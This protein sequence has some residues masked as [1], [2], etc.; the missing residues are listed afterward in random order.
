MSTG[1]DEQQ[2]AAAAAAALPRAVLVVGGAGAGKTALCRALIAH[3]VRD[4][5][6]DRVPLLLRVAD[7]AAAVRGGALRV[8]DGASLVLGYLRVTHGAHSRHFA[9]V[10]QALH[11]GRLLLILDGL[12]DAADPPAAA[13][14]GLAGGATRGAAARDRWATLPPVRARRPARPK[15]TPRL[16]PAELFLRLALRPPRRAAAVVALGAR[17]L[18]PPQLAALRRTCTRWGQPSSP[19][20]AALLVG[21]HTRRPP[22]AA[23]RTRRLLRGSRPHDAARRC[24]RR[25]ASRP[26]DVDAPAAAS[27]GVGAAARAAQLRLHV[28]KLV[29]TH[30]FGLGSDDG[31]GRGELTPRLV[32]AA[33]G[34]SAG[35]LQL[36]SQLRREALSGALP[37]LVAH[38]GGALA[39]A[40]ARF[41]DVL[42]ALSLRDLTEAQIRAGAAAPLLAP[43]PPPDT[44]LRRDPAPTPHH[45]AN[46]A[47]PAGAVGAGR[48]LKQG[49]DGGSDALVFAAAHAQRGGGGGGAWL[50][51]CCEAVSGAALR[52]QLESSIDAAKVAI[53]ARHSRTLVGLQLLECA[54]DDAGAES[55]A[56]AL[57]D[58][59]A[60]LPLRCLPSDRTDR[61]A[62]RRRP[63]RRC[64]PGSRCSASSTTRWA[65]AAR[66]RSRRKSAAAAAARH[67]A[68]AAAAGSRRRRRGRR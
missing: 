48:V 66:R 37:L 59:G 11:E 12:G 8:S 20:L 61:R 56:A 23:A 33:V 51:A 53:V 45:A 46:F 2:G 21:A 38:R 24:R 1:G 15:G 25:A 65:I 55:L 16:L 63:R 26:E 18:A 54:V 30:A 28:L 44:P 42:V 62:R 58:G 29:A 64:R 32:E 4:R 39:F 67:P 68:A 14:N 41:A 9:L 27:G 31:G 35:A 19:L 5:R 57:A 40:D 13:A 7:V 50:R 52:C 34:K 60:D 49:G 6:R 17:R 3:A 47:W 36:W 22:A 43:P 10:K